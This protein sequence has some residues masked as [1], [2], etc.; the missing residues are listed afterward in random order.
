M[1]ARRW[2]R[3]VTPVAVLLAWEAAS[4]GGVIPPAKLPAPSTVLET[5]WRLARDGDLGTHLGDSLTRA[6][7]GLAIGGALGVVLG[8]VA[9]LV[10]LGDDLV[11]PPVQMAR[12]L[13]HL[14]LVPLVI[15]W[16]GIDESLKVTLVALGAFFPLY[17]NT[18]A[19]IRDVD[20]RLVEAARTCGL[21]TLSRVRHVVLPGSLPS[22]LLGLRLAIAA[23]WLSLVVGEQV[24]AQS[25][26]GF[27][28]MEA[29]EFSQIDVVVL[30]LF[31]YGLLGL[32][33]DLILRAVERRALAW[34]V[35]LK[36]S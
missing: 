31:V 30:G 36:A 20:E 27:M 28:M 24:A 15:V 3:A 14:A 22:L 25:G 16:V 12:M 18:Y 11:D 8:T 10:R 6:A 7:L 1:T 29:R 21:S 23:A 35:G 33:S 4:R 9:G 26:I 32:A 2:R 17:L 19:G 34:R 5:G 13:P